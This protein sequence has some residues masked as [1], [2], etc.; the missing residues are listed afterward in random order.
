[1]KSKEYKEV[2]KLITNYIIKRNEKNIW[3]FKINKN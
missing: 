3:I 2:Y 1:M